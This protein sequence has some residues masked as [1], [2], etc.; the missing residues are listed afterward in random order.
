MK[1][2]DRKS[3]CAINF[4][5]E[6][7]GDPWSLLIVRDIVYFGKNTYGEF[8]GSAERIGTS[9]LA[10]R[11]AVLEK[12][13]ILSKSLSKIDQRKEEYHLTAK[14]LDLIPLLLDLTEWGAAHDPRTGASRKWITA[15]RTDRNTVIKRTQDIVRK[16]GSVLGDF[17][18]IV[19]K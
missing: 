8:L 2:T 6:T 7:F 19:N 4:A 14:G 9:V 12:K 11:L 1:R 5:L 15:I 13:G 16:G 17:D 3:D 18:R 10:H